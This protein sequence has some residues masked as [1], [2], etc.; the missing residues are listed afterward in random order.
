[1]LLDLKLKIDFSL[2][3]FLCKNIQDINNHLLPNTF[4]FVM[5]V[6]LIIELLL[7]YSFR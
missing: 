4:V 3:F 5:I 2:Y 7:L 6:C 1:M